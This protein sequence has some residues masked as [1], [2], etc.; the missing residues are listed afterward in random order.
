MLRRE[1]YLATYS[2]LPYQE[3]LNLQKRVLLAKVEGDFPDALIVLE[4][5]PVITL[6]RR[7]KEDH[8]VA[9][10]DELRR[11]AIEIFHV[12]RGGDVTYHGPGQIVGYPVF[13]LANY[14]RDLSR[15]VFSIEEVLIRVCQDLGIEACRKS[16]NRGVWVG[17]KKIASIGLAIRRWIS[18]HGFAFNWAPNMDHFRLITPC[19]L[20]GLEMTSVREILGEGT[21]PDFLRTLIYRHFEEVFHIH[22]QEVNLIKKLREGDA[23]E[24]SWRSQIHK[25]AR[26]GQDRGRSRYRRDH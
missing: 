6:G 17:D 9:S 8:I 25:G 1:V 19:G 7:G 4:H 24:H 15:F 16:I 23:Y 26:V 22:L 10:P 14:G 5:P 11:E 12:E 3:A 21:R 18:F 2:S 13:A 20:A